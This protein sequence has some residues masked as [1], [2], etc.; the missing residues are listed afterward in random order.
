[1]NELNLDFGKL[2][3]IGKDGVLHAVGEIKEIVEAEPDDIMIFKPNRAAENDKKVE[4]PSEK[5]MQIQ[6]E[7]VA[8]LSVQIDS[9]SPFIKEI[10]NQ[11]KKYL[12]DKAQYKFWKDQE[13][14][15]N[16]RAG[17]RRK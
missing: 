14:V 9:E 1:M 5:M 16:N 3:L 2:Y 12:R 8:S 4:S 10:Q 6:K 7:F 11:H 15:G 17:R 13:F